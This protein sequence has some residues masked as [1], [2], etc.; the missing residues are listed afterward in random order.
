MIGPD[1]GLRESGGRG[2][3]DVACAASSRNPPQPR[4]PDSATHD[5]RSCSQHHRQ[6]RTPYFAKS[7]TR[8]PHTAARR[9]IVGEMR[10]TRPRPAWILADQGG[11]SSSARPT[12][13]RSNSSRSS[14]GEARVRAQLPRVPPLRP[15][16]PA[17]LM[18]RESD[19]P[20][21]GR[22]P[23]APPCWTPSDPLEGTDGA[24]NKLAQLSPSVAA[25]AARA[26]DAGS[27]D[28]GVV[29]ALPRT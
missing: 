9:G 24:S 29:S 22:L 4:D 28:H 25:P 8:P 11:S 17:L 18:R 2:R 26:R 15:E 12:A 27:P 10:A 23:C 6:T 7:A 3:I 19:L 5:A 1:G 21:A 20:C 14:R 13:T 16:D